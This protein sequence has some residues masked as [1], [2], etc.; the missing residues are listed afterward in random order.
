MQVMANRRPI[1]GGIVWVLGA[2]FSRPL[3]GP[4]LSHMLGVWPEKALSGA[5]RRFPADLP[6]AIRQVQQVFAHGKEACS[7]LAPPRSL[8]RS[9][10]CP[11]I[12]PRIVASIPGVSKPA[13]YERERPVA[14]LGGVPALAAAGYGAY[15]AADDPRRWIFWLLV[16]AVVLTA[17]GFLAKVAQAGAKDKKQAHQDN[18]L[19]LLGCLLVLYE[20]VRREKSIGLSMKELDR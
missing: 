16:A 4:L 17:M 2:G 3:G 11:K 20:M 7:P 6:R 1:D 14:A 12:G 19:D 18:P 13:W 8:R 10:K 5:L 15:R 9:A